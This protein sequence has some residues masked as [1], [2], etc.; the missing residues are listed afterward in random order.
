[1]QEKVTSVGSLTV[2]KMTISTT[3][4][5]FGGLYPVLQSFGQEV[6]GAWNTTVVGRSTGVGVMKCAFM[7]LFLPIS[8][9]VFSCEKADGVSEGSLEVKFLTF[10][11]PNSVPSGK[12][13]DHS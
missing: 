11:L 10:L 5:G 8:F 9:R 13:V 12:L 6:D 4:R 3:R 7:W 1:M 2:S